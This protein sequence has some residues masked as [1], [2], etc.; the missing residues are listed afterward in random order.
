MV[1]T[2]R[3]QPNAPNQSDGVEGGGQRQTATNTVRHLWSERYTTFHGYLS[4]FSH[5]TVYAFMPHKTDHS[6]PTNYPLISAP[7]YWLSIPAQNET[8]CWYWSHKTINSCPIKLT[9]HSCSTKLLIPASQNWSS[10]PVQKTLNIHS[11]PPT[12]NIHSCP[13]KLIIH[14]ISRT[15][16]STSTH[17]PQK[18]T[19]C[20]C[21]T[22]S[23]YLFMSHKPAIPFLTRETAAGYLQSSCSVHPA[24]DVSQRHHAP[25]L[26]KSQSDTDTLCLHFMSHKDG[27]IFMIAPISL[28]CTNF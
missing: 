23:D 22:K 6:C 9:I 18:L 10:I 1:S 26:L 13:T 2:T 24:V 5:K 20:S 7:Q 14:S 4:E 3:G 16:Q 17:T 19:I 15:T 11:C 28:W 8:D 12:L 21:P 25:A 27:F